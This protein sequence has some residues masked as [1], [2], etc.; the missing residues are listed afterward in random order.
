MVRPD[1]MLVG[2]VGR[3]SSARL[4]WECENENILERLSLE[5]LV[6]DLVLV[7]RYGPVPRGS[8]LSA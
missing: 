2:E 5:N 1:V 6:V 3:S 7:E 4:A 8:V